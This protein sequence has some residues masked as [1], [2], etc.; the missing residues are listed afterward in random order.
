MCALLCKFVGIDEFLPTNTELIDLDLDFVLTL[1]SRFSEH[2]LILTL[3]CHLNKVKINAFLCRLQSIA[4]HRDNFV[5]RPSVC[6]SVRLSHFSVTLSKAMF[7]NSY[8]PG[9]AKRVL[10]VA[11]TYC[12]TRLFSAHF[13]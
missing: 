3:A 5:L 1:T 9:H 7:K 10:S 2:T 6:L 13:I 4:T 11:V 8:E 12:K